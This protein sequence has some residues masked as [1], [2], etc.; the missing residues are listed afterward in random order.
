MMSIINLSSKENCYLS[1]NTLSDLC[2]YLTFPF[3]PFIPPS[4]PHSPTISLFLSFSFFI[5]LLFILYFSP[6]H[7][8]FLSFSFFISFLFILYFSI[9]HSITSYH[10]QSSCRS[11]EEGY[12][13]SWGIMVRR[14]R[15][16]RPYARTYL[17]LSC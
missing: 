7:S 2:L 4:I 12:H 10:C 14:T 13:A 6:F 1:S 8:L 3:P 9:S 15:W 5:S 16:W 17:H 11:Q